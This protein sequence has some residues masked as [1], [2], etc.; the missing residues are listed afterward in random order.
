MTKKAKPSNLFTEVNPL[1]ASRRAKEQ[2][3][4]RDVL[5]QQ[6]CDKEHR[7]KERKKREQEE[8]LYL[9]QKLER[10]RREIEARERNEQLQRQR[11]YDETKKL[12]EQLFQDAVV[13]SKN[14]EK[15]T[16]RTP[17]VHSSKAENFGDNDYDQIEKMLVRN[18]HNELRNE[19][20][21]SIE[22]MR[23]EFSMSNEK[24]RKQIDLLK[25]TTDNERTQ[26]KKLEEE[27]QKLRNRQKEE[28]AKEELRK[29][30]V[31]GSLNENTS[32]LPR[33]NK[34]N[35]EVKTLIDPSGYSEILTQQDPRREYRHKNR[36]DFKKHAKAL[37]NTSGVDETIILQNLQDDRLDK[38]SDIE[39][40]LRVDDRE[41]YINEANTLSRLGYFEDP[42]GFKNMSKGKMLGASSQFVSNGKKANH[43]VDGRRQSEG[44]MF[45]LSF[46][47]K[48]IPKGRHLDDPFI[49]NLAL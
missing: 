38:I 5:Q 10:E 26:K 47:P 2:D 23:Q 49:N 11:Q 29:L 31:L 4:W 14:I 6:M 21:I 46:Q 12:N 48:D 20:G 43:S 28:D 13:R 34:I 41:R 17:Q 3:E 35:F 42:Y 36:Y 45:N 25:K 7:E 37:L 19:F 1:E 18:A 40:S 15:H 22:R 32:K 27:L 16:Y 8:E 33:T 30:I 9:E 24:M 39:R 44:T